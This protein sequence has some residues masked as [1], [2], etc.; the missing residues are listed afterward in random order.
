MKKKLVYGHNYSLLIFLFVLLIV[1]VLF[2]FCVSRK[3][4]Y[5][6]ASSTNQFLFKSNYSSTLTLPFYADRRGCNGPRKVT[7]SHRHNILI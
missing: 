4:W 6:A 7:T 3:S 1:Y 2:C 5:L